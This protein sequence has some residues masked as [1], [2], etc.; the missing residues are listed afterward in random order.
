MKKYF[1]V[2]Q[3]TAIIV[4]K[5]VDGN[6]LTRTLFKNRIT[7]KVYEDVEQL[8][9]SDKCKK[10]WKHLKNAFE[11][12]VELNDQYSLNFKEFGVFDK[13][14]GQYLNDKLS[15]TV[16]EYLKGISSLYDAKS[17][18]KIDAVV[19]FLKKLH[20]SDSYHIIEE[21]LDFVRYNDIEISADGN[22]ICYKVVDQNYKDIHT[23]SINNSVGKVVVMN[24]NKVSDDR[25]ESCSYG[26]H[27]ASLRY[28]KSSGYGCGSPNNHLMKLCV[29]PKDFVSV[30]YDYDGAKARVC[31]YEVV[32]EV[33]MSLIETAF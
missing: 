14:N 1:Y 10:A 6:I 3:P 15:K 23:H 32:E 24:R 13:L 21:L 17:D 2:K 29:N 16:I 5:R 11:N 9:E 20:E 18:L 26:L 31:R 12:E 33:D 8:L 22:I 28:L 30:P 7:E 27:V 4:H 19:N 25:N